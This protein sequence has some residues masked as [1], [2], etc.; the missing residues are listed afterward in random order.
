MAV[1]FTRAPTV[2]AGD[3]ITSTQF[4]SLAAAFN[5]RVLSGLGDPTFRIFFYFL[6]LC[7]QFR[8]PNDAGTTYPSNHEFFEFY[9][10]VD[11]A[12]GEYPL[13]GPGDPE[14]SN[15]AAQINS[16]VFGA[17][18]LGLD[19]E[20]TRLLDLPFLASEPT[21]A[22]AWQIAKAQ[23]GA[24]DPSTGGMG[25][26]AF[27][28][29]RS[30]WRIR[31][32]R[33]SPHG[34]SYGGFIGVPPEVLPGCADP[35][36]PNYEVKFTSLVDGSTVTYGSCA[37]NSG[38]VAGVA[39][40]PWAYYVVLNSGEVIQYDA[41]EWVEGPYT[42]DAALMKRPA[43]GIQRVLNAYAGE[44]RGTTAMR[45]SQTY[46]LQHAFDFQRF[47]ESQYH[48]APAYGVETAGSLQSQYPRVEQNS[49]ATAGTSMPFIG[50]GTTY[51]FHDGFILAS[52]IVVATNL[53]ESFSVELLDNG[54]VV[55]TI[56]VRPSEAGV[57]SSLW[58]P[59]TQFRSPTLSVRV[60]AG[61]EL[62]FRPGGGT[63]A[64]EFAEL[65]RYKPRVE[66]YAIFLRASS[67]ID[68]TP[69]GAGINE[70]QAKEIG[71]GYFAKGCLWNIN[72]RESVPV[73]DV[74]VNRNAVFD[75]FRRL[76]R[77]CVRVIRR[78]ELV[79]YEVADGKSILYV[80]RH[81]M[82]MANQVPVDALD[83]V[84][85]GRDRIPSGEIKW[86]RRYKVR[87]GNIRYRD[88]V[89]QAGE[90]FTGV[91]GATTYTGGTELYDADGI[92]LVAP[93]QDYSNRW[94]IDVE[95]RPYHPSESSIWK[96]SSFSDYWAVFNRC[97]FASPE[98]GGD[99]YTLNHFAY[100]LS[101]GGRVLYPE[102]PTGYNY[103]T[104][105]TAY[106]GAWNANELDC[107]GDPTCEETRLNFY[108][109]CRIYEPPV[110]IE[111]VEW[112]SGSGHDEV[113]KVTLTGR[114]HHTDE[115][116]ETISSD[117]SS[118]DV[119]ALQ[120]EPYRTAENGIR[121][122]LVNQTSGENCPFGTG[123]QALNGTI[124]LDPDNPFGACFPSI[125]LTR[126]VPEP[127]ADSNDAQNPSDTR[128]E[129]DAFRV[130]EIYL[131]AMCEGYVDGET[132]TEY[133]C[134][135]GTVTVFDY[136]LENL[137]L[138]AT[139]NR[140]LNTF[141]WSDSEDNREGF[142]PMPNTEAMASIFN[143][144]SA[145][146][147]LLTRVRVMVPCQIEARRDRATVTENTDALAGD[148]STVACDGASEVWIT[149]T[150][151]SPEPDASLGT[152][153]AT[154]GEGVTSSSYLTGL[155]TGNQW[156]VETFR[157]AVEFR[158]AP[159][160]ADISYAFPESWRAQFDDSPTFLFQVDRTDIYEVRSLVTD[161][162]DATTCG[163]D[164]WEVSP[165][166]SWYK[167]TEVSTTETTCEMGGK[168]WTSPELP[169]A[170]TFYGKDGAT[171]CSQA[172][173]SRE[174]VVTPLALD[175]P[176]LEIELVD[177]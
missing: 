149:R 176:I 148:G 59:T 33:R 113:L 156:Q 83:G 29:A 58:F 70:S 34:N 44:F 120:A 103:T 75:T 173:P 24:Y 170:D 144:Y 125:R 163:G 111:S 86:G 126:L 45:E 20:S 174:I 41:N 61:G 54:E 28:A 48:L 167:W 9:M 140:W 106:L 1:T 169:P 39:E 50:H 161:I 129:H 132:S 165:G 143:Q 116:D 79:G 136:T 166:A 168:S 72:N 12:D 84:G 110:E 46:H 63:F 127:Y 26:P 81:V 40:M 158:Y 151:A 145:C 66:D 100:G 139:G 49:N 4:A 17:E 21:D 6:A 109:S 78:Q 69:D 73:S 87:T 142:G 19:A 60:K 150:A 16:Y 42:E 68:A 159:D 30:H 141:E 11:P 38:D 25:A 155:C 64:I 57:V 112:Y 27:T 53:A 8:N 36:E 147:N 85:P 122:Y 102:A 152:W 37:E 32:S 135:H 23:R 171:T 177:P 74:A 22:E 77:S 93:P 119:A 164:V 97:L 91:S 121:S 94:C 154:S 89:Y 118:W 56:A 31:S 13:S 123:D 124:N 2:A 175:V 133:A 172:G 90:E 43:N 105:G 15:V 101:S 62:R 108:K 88:R 96:P 117:I 153:A 115:A 52:A 5:D 10:H 128:F 104:L 82:G 157:E 114:L 131:R 47:A 95:L 67:A 160:N 107:A 18:A 3:A 76:A 7:R 35:T 146:V 99:K 71:D 98:I 162:G 55:E 134:E 51:Q 138:Q 92:R 137:C 130:M 65:L 80:R 14:G